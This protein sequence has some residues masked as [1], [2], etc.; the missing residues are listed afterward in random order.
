[1]NRL[2]TFWIASSSVLFLLSLVYL[3]YQLHRKNVLFAWWLCLGVAMQLITAYAMVLGSHRFLGY[4]WRA[5]DMAS[6]VL[7]AGVL[8]LAYHRRSCAV[9]R[10]LLYGLGTMLA[11]NLITRLTAGHISMVKQTWLQD[12]AFFGPALFLLVSFSN[13]R[14]DRIPL[15]ICSS[16]RPMSLRAS[17]TPG[18]A[19]SC[20]PIYL[21]P[22]EISVSANEASP[23]YSI[24]LSSLNWEL[25]RNPFEPPST[26]DPPETVCVKRDRRE[27]QVFALAQP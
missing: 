6:I 9:N 2:V 1:M 22:P 5:A 19:L 17:P 11:F 20:R 14:R 15:H 18:L 3:H 12:I 16:L 7:A 27:S 10:T 13:I 21:S 23:E 8:I 25:P 24:A 26:P 4:L